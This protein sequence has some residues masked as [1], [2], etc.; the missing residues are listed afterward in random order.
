MIIRTSSV[1]L[2]S[3][4][5]VVVCIIAVNSRNKTDPIHTRVGYKVLLSCDDGATLWR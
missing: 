2:M 4:L 3:Q 1:R 5:M